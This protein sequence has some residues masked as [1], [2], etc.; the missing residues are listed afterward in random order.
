MATPPP[1]IHAAAT[2]TEA[3]LLIDGKTYP[4]C[5]VYVSIPDFK[6]ESPNGPVYYGSIKMPNP[7]TPPPGWGFIPYVVDSGGVFF[8]SRNGVAENNSTD[9][10][11]IQV[12]WNYPP[13]LKKLG[14][15]L[16][17]I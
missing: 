7:F 2:A 11:I 10:R 14:W 3:T 15:R 12:A 8:V 9:I 5:G 13:V 6:Y 1:L 16:A 4:A 17:R